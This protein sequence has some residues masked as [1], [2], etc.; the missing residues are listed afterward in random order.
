MKQNK[1]AAA[2]LHMLAAFNASV[3]T[4]PKGGAAKRSFCF[5]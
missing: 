3:F 5:A 4:A 1:K 2:H